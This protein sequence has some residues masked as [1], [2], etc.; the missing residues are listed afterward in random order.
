MTSSGNADVGDDDVAGSASRPAAARAAAS[1]RPAS[2]SSSASIA[3]AD[4]LVRVGRQP[5]RQ[6]DRRRPACRCRS[7]RRRPSRA[8]PS[9]GAFSPVPKIASTIEVHCEISEKCSSHACCRRSRRPSRPS[10]PR[11]SRLMRASPRDVGDAADQEH[12]DVDAAL[13]AACA[14]RRSRRRRCCRGRTARR[15]GA[16]AGRRERASIAATTWRPA[17][18][19]STSDGMPISS[20][21]RRSASR[22]CAAFSTRIVTSAVGTRSHAAVPGTLVVRIDARWSTSTAASPTRR[23]RSS[24]SSITASSTA[25]ASTRRCAPTTASRSCSTATCAGCARRRRMHRAGR[26][27]HR[28]RASLARIRETMARGRPGRSGDEAYI[29]ILLTRGVGELTYDPAACPTPSIVII[30]KPHVDPPAEALRATAS[31]VA[32]VT[33]VRNHP[34]I[35]EPADQVEQPA[36]QRAGDAGGVPRAAR[37]KA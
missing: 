12:R 15:P 18:S 35:G 7:R 8:C 2:P 37:S 4:R 34:G 33:I 28:R 24:R 3:V 32:L 31:R 1:A 14:R 29:R 17:F 19:I 16:R 23:T 11:I 6:V 21:V 9:S 22:I 36:E 30:V 10:R 20:I 13:R 5:G 26:A 27:V 25:K